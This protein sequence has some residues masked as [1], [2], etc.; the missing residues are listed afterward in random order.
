MILLGQKVSN[1]GSS[2]PGCDPLNKCSCSGIAANTHPQSSISS[3]IYL[4]KYLCNLQ[5]DSYFFHAKS[6]SVL[7][8]GPRC[9]IHLPHSKWA[10]VITFT[11]VLA[12]VFL[13]YLP[14]QTYLSGQVPLSGHTKDHSLLLSSR[15][16]RCKSSIICVLVRSIQGCCLK[17]Q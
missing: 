10:V 3:E 7:F 9:M 14:W 1:D 11:L 5:R 4:F 17:G 16:V 15:V 8:L 6:F 12:D 13:P 2:A